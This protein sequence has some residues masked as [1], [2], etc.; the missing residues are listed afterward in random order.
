MH[1]D[2]LQVLLLAKYARLHPSTRVRFHTYLPHLSALG[3]DVSLA[4]LLP[5]EYTTNLFSGMRTSLATLGLA[6]LRRAIKVAR[7]RAYDVVWLEGELWPRSPAWGEALLDAIHC[8]VVVDYDDAVFHRYD[9]SPNPFVRR[10][11][12]RK[13]DTVMRHA[14]AVVVANQYLRERAAAAGATVIHTVP[15]VVDLDRYRRCPTSATTSSVIGWIGSPISAAFLESVA[16]TLNRVRQATG[17]VIRIIGAG[18]RLNHDFKAEFRSWSEDSEVAEICKF[19]AG[20]MPLVDSPVARGKSGYKLIQYMACRVP[21]VASP[22]GENGTIIEP[23]VDG[24]LA[25]SDE[26]W[27]AA[28]VELM[29]SAELR[30][31]LGGSGR[32]KVERSYSVQVTGPRMA[33]ILTKAAG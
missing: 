8:P 19:T 5:E 30:E 28:L 23:H 2:R 16:L 33:S 4:P 14:T 12:G 20:I 1:K 17:A 25:S 13:I 29:Q 21:V 32:A 3:I 15:S 24:L 11:M 18:P 22:V 27:Y 6:Y 31:R 9:L 26:E 7:A 10:F